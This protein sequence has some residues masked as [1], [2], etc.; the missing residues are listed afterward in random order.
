PQVH[1]NLFVDNPFLVVT[2]IG[3]TVVIRAGGID[4]SVGAVIALPTL[5][6]ATLLERHGV[7]PAAVNALALLL[8]ASLGF[9][10]GLVIQTFQIQPFIVTLAGMFLARGLCYLISIDSIAITNPFYTRVSALRFSLPFDTSISMNVFIALAVLAAAVY[11]AH[12]TRFGR[13]VYAI[14][15]SEQSALLMGL[16]VAKTKILIY[17]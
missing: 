12:Y 13:T 8:G 10:Q 9:V 2:A 4:V 5:L 17:T 6:P 7:N 16:P 15:G 11:L 1:L 3:M 14:G